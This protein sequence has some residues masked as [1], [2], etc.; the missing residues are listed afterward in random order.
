[1]NREEYNRCVGDGMR[2][3]TL[4]KEERRAEFC[5]VAKLCSGKAKDRE[6]AVH[7]CSAPKSERAKRDKRRCLC[8][9]ADQQTADMIAEQIRQQGVK[10]QWKK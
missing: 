7:L 8:L 1:M 2:G 6:E 5:A 10:A 9:D 3:K 4:T